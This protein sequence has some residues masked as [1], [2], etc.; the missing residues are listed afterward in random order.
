MGTSTLLFVAFTVFSI[1]LAVFAQISSNPTT[2]PTM[3]E[4]AETLLQLESAVPFTRPP[5]DNTMKDSEI[6]PIIF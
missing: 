1:P 2:I 4:W 3:T 5:V 6:N